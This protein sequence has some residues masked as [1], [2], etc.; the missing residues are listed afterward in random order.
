MLVTCIYHGREETEYF[1]EAAKGERNTV[2]PVIS[3]VDA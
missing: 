1:N 3:W 2:Q